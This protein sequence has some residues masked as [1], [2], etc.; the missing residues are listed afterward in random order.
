MDVAAQDYAYAMMGIYEL[1]D[2]S[3][4]TDLFVWTYRRSIKK[5]AV[6][7][8]SIGGPDPFRLKYREVLSAVVQHIIHD[9]WSMVVAAE[10]A[11]LPADD[12]ARFAEMVKGELA[13]LTV[14]NCARYRLDI[15]TVE[16]WIARGRSS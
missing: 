14:H 16:K 5:Y 12:R 8:E 13:S 4:A 7:M 10:G 1:L 6:V 15:K 9:G 11:Q 3:L 2:V